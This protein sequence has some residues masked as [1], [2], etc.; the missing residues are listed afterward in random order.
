METEFPAE[1]VYDSENVSA[2]SGTCRRELGIF[3]LGHAIVRMRLLHELGEQFS[4][5]GCGELVRFS[6]EYV[7][8]G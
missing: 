7:L 3:Y 8:M 2:H 6:A 1:W 4:E 5:S